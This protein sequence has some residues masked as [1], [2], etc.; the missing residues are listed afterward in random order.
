MEIGRGGVI[1]VKSLYINIVIMFLNI[2]KELVYSSH[3]VEK[4]SVIAFDI[5]AF[6]MFY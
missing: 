2:I 6:S 5:I 1:F 4:D 3:I